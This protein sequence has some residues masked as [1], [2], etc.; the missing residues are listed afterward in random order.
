MGNF[1]GSCFPIGV[2]I[3]PKP[4]NNPEH[5]SL[6]KVPYQG[7]FG[8]FKLSASKK[9]NYMYNVSSQVEIECTKCGKMIIYCPIC[10]KPEK[11]ICFHNNLVCNDYY[12]SQVNKEIETIDKQRRIDASKQ[13]CN[14]CGTNQIFK[15]EYCS[16]LKWED[17]ELLDGGFGA[18]ISSRFE[19]SRSVCQLCS[20]MGKLC[21][22]CLIADSSIFNGYCSNCDIRKCG[23]CGERGKNKF[24]WQ[25]KRK[26][27]NGSP[28]YFC[29]CDTCKSKY[30]CGVGDTNGYKCLEEKASGLDTCIKHK[31][32]YMNLCVLCRSNESLGYCTVCLKCAT[33]KLPKRCG[34]CLK[35]KIECDSTSNIATNYMRS[36]ICNVCHHN[37]GNETCTEKIATHY[38]QKKT[39]YIMSKTTTNYYSNG[40]SSLPINTY[41]E[42]DPL[43]ETTAK[44]IICNCSELYS[45][46]YTICQHSFSSFDYTGYEKK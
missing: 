14:N 26:S 3:K 30:L 18:R 39:R 46:Q 2:F 1:I 29:A 22:G 45:K 31:S 35:T 38:N 28:N 21:K 43:I 25:L 8:P 17:R 32:H 36:K 20:Q 41:E 40:C 13:Y 6:R 9:D 23:Y 19:Y 12:Q 5:K 4:C 27:N 34:M 42:S 44:D 24:V 10:E 16:P 7:R 37:H 11:F 33:E 15:K